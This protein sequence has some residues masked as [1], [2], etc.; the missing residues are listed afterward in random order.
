MI[1]ARCRTLKQNIGSL[2]S[3]LA[4]ERQSRTEVL[5]EVLANDQFARALLSSSPN[6]VRRLSAW[7]KGSGI[8]PRRRDLNSLAQFVVRCAGKTSP[9]STLTAVGLG[10]WSSG[11]SSTN[12]S[13]GFETA[14]PVTELN[15]ATYQWLAHLLANDPKLRDLVPLRVNPTGL[16]EG[17]RLWWAPFDV[18]KPLINIGVSS[19]VRACFEMHAI[20]TPTA[21]NFLQAV[22]K[23]DEQSTPGEVWEFLDELIVVGLLERVLPVADQAD[24]GLE[25]LL[26]WVS[27][28]LGSVGSPADLQLVRDD[29]ARLNAR[30]REYC[31]TTRLGELTGLSEK[32]GQA[33]RDLTGRFEVG[34]S[35]ANVTDS[36]VF[37]DSLVLPEPMS[38]RPERFEMALNDLN[39]VRRGLAVFDPKMPFR[40]GLK[41]CF[42]GWFGAGAAVSFIDFVRKYF[43]DGPLGPADSGLEGLRLLLTPEHEQKALASVHPGIREPVEEHIGLRTRLVDDIANTKANEEGIIRMPTDLLLRHIDSWPATVRAPKSI[44][45]YAQAS[46]TSDMLILNSIDTGYGRALARIR[47]LMP[48]DPLRDEYVE[49]SD[50]QAPILAELDALFGNSV[51][52]RRQSVRY[53]IEYAGSVS[54]RSRHCRLA[55]RDL[56]VMHVAEQDRLTLFDDRLQR[57]VQPVHTGLMWDALLPPVIRLLM[58]A[59]AEPAT[60]VH[61]NS[62]WLNIDPEYDHKGVRYYPRIDFGLITLR[63]AF[64]TSYGR[65]VPRYRQGQSDDNFLLE[66]IEWLRANSMPERSFV[67]VFDRRVGRLRKNRKPMLLDTVNWFLVDV[68]RRRAILE[69][70]LVL[71]TEELPPTSTKLNDAFRGDRVAE[72]VFEVSDGALLRRRYVD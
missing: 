11:P 15:V 13:I 51:N 52:A 41:T 59:F 34:R 1:D 61:P 45:V 10:R 39:V 33:F 16:T 37:H 18:R 22:I 14:V 60:Y 66:I 69:D 19:A 12:V 67:R 6:L 63:R 9:K 72:F 35:T 8:T 42:T 29:L 31:R 24:D 65:E 23:A 43:Q 53:A 58:D 70:D 40:I 7:L 71:F 28:T 32:I 20:D 48:V 68:F 38:L 27:S 55:F 30:L 26:N 21:A 64:W 25:A 62:W 3:V 44:S 46:A 5:R 54:A 36:V 50:I 57:E 17:S 2:S 49:Y 4:E 47:K 56:S